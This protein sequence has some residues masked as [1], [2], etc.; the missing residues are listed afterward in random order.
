M[1]GVNDLP[2]HMR[3]TVN[4]G[5]HDY[6]YRRSI[7]NNQIYP[8]PGPDTR[9]WEKIDGGAIDYADVAAMEHSRNPDGGPEVHDGPKIKA[10]CPV[11]N[12]AEAVP[13]GRNMNSEAA[14]LAALRS[15]AAQGNKQA[16]EAL[17]AK[18]EPTV[19]GD[20]LIEPT[21]TPERQ[22]QIDA[23]AALREQQAEQER[24]QALADQAAKAQIKQGVDPS[25][26]AQV[27]GAADPAFNAGIPP[28]DPDVV[29]GASPE[30]QEQ[31]MQVLSTGVAPE[32]QAQVAE[33][34]VEQ[35]DRT[36]PAEM[37]A[38]RAELGQPTDTA[39]VTNL[40]EG[41]GRDPF[42]GAVV[43][44]TRNPGADA[45]APYGRKK[46]GSPRKPSGPRQA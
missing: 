43:P 22:A 16:Q 30:V 40:P 46:D 4:F 19:Q 34:L 32:V 15:L 33:T 42:T 23:A 9:D 35:A 44:I 25:V 3:G 38:A 5:G 39:P 14:R 20:T 27:T 37:A 12:G 2:V 18:G 1:A 26:A 11:C 28:T 31:S 24:I 29:A 6:H 17:A 45:E 41:H 13:T 8:H 21:R 10:S 36:N 7:L